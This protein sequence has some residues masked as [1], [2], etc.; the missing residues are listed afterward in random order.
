MSN[1]S[2]EQALAK[3]NSMDW[4]DNQAGV[5]DFV[6]PK[7]TIQMPKKKTTDLSMLSVEELQNEYVISLDQLE[8]IKDAP[9]ELRQYVSDK[10]NKVFGY[11]LAIKRELKKK[12]SKE[13]NLLTYELITLRANAES[14]QES[15]KSKNL[16]EEIERLKIELSQARSSN[17]LKR[18]QLKNDNIKKAN[19]REILIH[20]KFK[21]LVKEKIGLDSYMILI[22]EADVL[23]DAELNK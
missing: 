12:S 22:R 11:M 19:A 23:A 6:K 17:S 16:K 3:A 1:L 2:D 14:N 15:N 13:Q 20:H 9:K 5:I 4:F 21:Q 18:E 10:S 8:A 7:K